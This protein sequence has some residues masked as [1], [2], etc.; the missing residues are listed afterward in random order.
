MEAAEGGD[1]R[2]ERGD[3]RSKLP[4][5]ECIEPVS[6]GK[7]GEGGV[8]GGRGLKGVWAMGR[9]LLGVWLFREWLE[10]GPD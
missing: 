7:P 6:P 8:V 2:K 5:A 4:P 1:P 10:E 3:P 9:G